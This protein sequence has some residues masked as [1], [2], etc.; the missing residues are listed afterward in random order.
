[1]RRP[2]VRGRQLAGDV[3]LVSLREG[4]AGARGRVPVAG[5]VRRQVAEAGRLEMSA[6][7]IARLT[8]SLAKLPC[9]GEKTAQRLAF[10]IL[11]SPPD[12]A[13]EL[14]EALLALRQAVRLCSVC[15]N[16]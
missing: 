9:V 16:L 11:K 3:H 4:R 15:C 13:R 2:G 6:D 1:A 8:L 14:A 5:E 12:Y 10:H 7:P